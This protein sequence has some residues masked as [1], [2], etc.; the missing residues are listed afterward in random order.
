MM[1]DK[2]QNTSAPEVRRI[3]PVMLKVENFHIHLDERSTSNTY[4]NGV[5]DQD[6]EPDIDIEAM[7]ATI[8]TKTGLCKDAVVMVLDAQA[9]YLDSVYGE[10]EVDEDKLLPPAKLSA[11]DTAPRVQDVPH[12]R[13]KPGKRPR[14][15]EQ[16]TPTTMEETPKEPT[17]E[18]QAEESPDEEAKEKLPDFPDDSA[19]DLPF[20]LDTTQKA[21]PEQPAVTISK[22]EITAVIVAKIKQKRS[23]NE[24]IGQLLKTYGVGQL[25]ELPAAK[26]EAF[27]ADISQL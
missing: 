26:Y 21:E 19:D 1:N 23:N 16:D 24:K 22:D 15:Q 5:E 2:N 3:L 11:V 27:L 8:C 6:E 9:E 10:D 4:F 7:I 17:E 20:D 18:A 25:S 13:K 12:P 14:K